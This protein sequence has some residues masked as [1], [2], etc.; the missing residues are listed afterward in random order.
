MKSSTRSSP[1]TGGT[2]NHDGGD[3]GHS[4]IYIA[5]APPNLGEVEAPLSETAEARLILVQRALR[6]LQPLEL[7]AP[8][9]IAVRPV[10]LAGRQFN[11]PAFAQEV[12]RLGQAG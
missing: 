8:R 7:A 11:P 3:P 9:P 4:Y 1:N 2:W 5:A 12:V 6:P 10:D